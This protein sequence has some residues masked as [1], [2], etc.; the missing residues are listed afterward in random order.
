M[1]LGQEGNDDN[2]GIFFD[3]LDNNGILSVLIR[4]TLM[5]PF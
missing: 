4:I 1:T 3:L 2:L 5:R